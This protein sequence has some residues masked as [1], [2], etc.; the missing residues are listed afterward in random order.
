MSEVR[1]A[2]GWWAALVIILALAAFWRVAYFR[3]AAAPLAGVDAR[4]YDAIA[5]TLLRE[6]RFRTPAHGMP[7]GEYAVRT[8]GYPAFLAA[9]YWLGERE[10]GSRLA[11]LRPVQLALDLAT[12]LIT[13]AL[14]RRLL[15][16]RRAIAA[17]SLYAA[18]PGFWW[19]ASAAYSETLAT[20]LWAAGVLILT[21]GFEGRRARA[22]IGA[23][24]ILGLAA[25]VR[26][27]GQA[28]AIFLLV[29]LIW[30]YGIRDRRWAGHFCAFA[31]AFVV[32][33]APWAARNSMIFHRPV[34]LSSYGGLNF[35]VGNYLP[36]RGTFR[37]ATYAIVNRI[38][39][40]T[41]DEMAA[42]AALW[43]AGAANIGHYLVHRPL[44]YAGLLWRK[45]HTFWD[46][47]GGMAAVVTWHGRGLY[48]WQLHLALLLLGLV[49]ML[50]AT[51]S[52]GRFAPALA[53]IAFTC[54]AHVATIAE[55]G[56]YNLL[57]MPYVMI[58]AAAG[59]GWFFP[60]LLG[61][62]TSDLPPHGRSGVP[63]AGGGGTSCA[64]LPQP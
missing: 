2:R 7:H 63:T 60:G 43:R 17:A 14:A 38:T 33:T 22:Y 15:G 29:P 32:V 61:Q 19:A 41:H 57:V 13:F 6:G 34:G 31:V 24:A 25:L 51:F 35:F 36:Y 4:E 53:A 28:F 48:G 50:V 49:G 10:L 54:L 39:A 55:E 45:F 23:G 20:F 5:T 37:K 58:L 40:G 52:A 44:G 46:S 59:L 64:T 1:L 16:R 42:D 62:K 47:Y 56:R 30:A 3:G 27:T 12:L 18:Y 11:L 8:P 26:P 21:A 9:L